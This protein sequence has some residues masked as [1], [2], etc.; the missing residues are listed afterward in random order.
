MQPALVSRPFR[1]PGWVYEE[2]YDGWRLLAYKRGQCVQLVSRAGRDHTHRFPTLVAAIA[3][4][5][6]DT[7]VLDGEVCIFDQQLITRFEWLRE[8]PFVA[9]GTTFDEGIGIGGRRDGFIE[10]RVIID[11][12]DPR[13]VRRAGVGR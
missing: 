13:G 7:L 9:Q 4:L 10:I 1:R 3:N 11:A 12:C 5:A 6:P 8:R 2:K